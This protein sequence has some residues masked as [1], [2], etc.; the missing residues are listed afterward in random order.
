MTS[1]TQKLLLELAAANLVPLVGV[2]AFGWSML[3]IFL[4]YWI[5]STFIGVLAIRTVYQRSIPGGLTAA[6]MRCLGALILLLSYAPS[7]YVMFVIFGRD[8]ALF[9]RPDSPDLTPLQVMSEIP[10]I[11]AALAVV[12]AAT[13]AHFTKSESYLRVAHLP[14]MIPSFARL[15]ALCVVMMMGYC[16]LYVIPTTAG[17]LVLLIAAK[18]LGE[19]WVV[20]KRRL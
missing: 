17:T 19:W 6:L 12:G 2:V 7:I 1:R 15:M 5:E 20:T 13:W 14:A 16:L 18:C 8:T 3:E 10:F 11:I 9:W 4:I